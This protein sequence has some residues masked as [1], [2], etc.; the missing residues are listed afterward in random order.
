MFAWSD[1]KPFNEVASEFKRSIRVLEDLDAWASVQVELTEYRHALDNFYGLR[2]V[3]E[4]VNLSIRCPRCDAIR[5]FIR[6]YPRHDR[7]LV[8]ILNLE[9]QRYLDSKGIIF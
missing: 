5:C 4:E 1:A 3:A 9:W 7:D 8:F 2:D 6:Y